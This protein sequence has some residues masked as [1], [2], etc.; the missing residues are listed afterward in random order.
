MPSLVVPS[1]INL[2]SKGKEAQASFDTCSPPNGEAWP[3]DS[4]PAA[5]TG[6][7]NYGNVAQTAQLSQTASPR[8]TSL[9]RKG[10]APRDQGTIDLSAEEEQTAQE[11]E[12]REQQSQSRLQ[13]IWK[14]KSNKLPKNDNSDLNFTFTNNQKSKEDCLEKP[15]IK[16]INRV[17]HPKKVEVGTELYVSCESPT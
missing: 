8:Q 12:I 17:A 1:V 7:I 3:Q 13:M 4:F 5:A 6:P 11:E 2:S 16:N 15:L 14:R 9:Y 10:A